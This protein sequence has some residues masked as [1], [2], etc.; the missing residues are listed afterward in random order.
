MSILKSTNTGK[1][2]L[3]E[4][5]VKQNCYYIVNDK[6]I[7]P[8]VKKDNNNE[9]K[10][11]CFEDEQAQYIKITLRTRIYQPKFPLGRFGPIRNIAY[12]QINKNQMI[13]K[14]EFHVKNNPPENIKFNNIF[15]DVYLDNENIADIS[16]AF[17][18][19]TLVVGEVIVQN[20]SQLDLIESTY[21]KKYNDLCISLRTVEEKE[22]I[23][24]HQKSNKINKFLDLIYEQDTLIILVILYFLYTQD[25]RNDSLMIC[26]LLLLLD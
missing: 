11:T 21:I 12:M 8:I 13:Q 22:K 16:N 14:V 6:K 24:N 19:T 2:S 4:Y 3:P 23:N 20:E 18:Y 1:Y 25:T 26:L 10:V 5:W 17:L 9:L 15:G 7:E